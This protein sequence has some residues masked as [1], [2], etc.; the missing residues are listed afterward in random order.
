[1]INFFEILQ[2]EDGLDPQNWQKHKEIAHQMIDDIFLYLSTVKDQPVWQKPPQHV[3]DNFNQPL[4]VDGEDIQS[5]YAEFLEYVLPYRTGNIHPRFFSWVHGSG[6]ITGVLGDMLAS[7]MNSNLAVGD[8]GAIYLEHNVL[9]WCKQIV[10]FPESSSGVL[11]SGAS[12]ANT[13][14]LIV[15]RDVMVSEKGLL[16]DSNLIIYCSS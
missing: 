14:A 15:A 7:A 4:P 12:I 13:T 3:K 10:G 5:V 8:H 9:N 6:T 16:T 11:V 2:N 1:M